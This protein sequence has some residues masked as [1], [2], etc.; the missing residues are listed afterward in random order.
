VSDTECVSL[1]RSVEVFFP[2]QGD[3][4]GVSQAHVAYVFRKLE[5][6]AG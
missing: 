6:L 2:V 4:P 5:C 1:S 3:L